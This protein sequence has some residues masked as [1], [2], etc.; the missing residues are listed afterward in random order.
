MI[1]VVVQLPNSAVINVPTGA[2][3][4][5]SDGTNTIE[6]GSLMTVFNLPDPDS[7]P[8]SEFD[9]LK[10]RLDAAEAKLAAPWTVN[11]TATPP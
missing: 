3:V 9:A 4:V 8:Q 2:S 10:V 6:G 11:G 5:I 7:V 1:L